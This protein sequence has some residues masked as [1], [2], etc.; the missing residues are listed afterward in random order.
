MDRLFHYCQIPQN[1]LSADRDIFKIN[2][3][4][5]GIMN[6]HPS[7]TNKR[8]I[9]FFLKTYPLKCAKNVKIV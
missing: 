3:S 5:L 7:P 1:N 6:W 2:A 9:F 8:L 4:R